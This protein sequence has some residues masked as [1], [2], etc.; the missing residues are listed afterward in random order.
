MPSED[1]TRQ[2][3]GV[4]TPDGLHDRITYLIAATARGMNPRAGADAVL[5]ALR[6]AGWVDPERAQMLRDD[7]RGAELAATEF[8]R[9][10]KGWL[11]EFEKAVAQAVR[12]EAERDALLPVVEAARAWRGWQRSRILDGPASVE[13]INLARAVDAL[14]RQE[15]T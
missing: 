15:T 8:D 10:S 11:G 7:L 2:T 1:Q 9:Q 13:E 12:A 6:D 3:G 4:V 5:S 14:P